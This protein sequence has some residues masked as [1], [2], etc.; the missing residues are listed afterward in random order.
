MFKILIVFHL[1]FTLDAILACRNRG[2]LNIKTTAC[3]FYNGIHMPGKTVF[4]LKRG[5]CNVI[6]SRLRHVG[7]WQWFLLLIE[8][9]TNGRH[10]A[11]DIKC[12]FWNENAWIPIKISLKF[13]PKDPINNIPS[14]VQIMA[15]RRPGDKPLSVPMM[16]SLPTHICVARS[17]W[18]NWRWL[19]K[20]A[21]GSRGE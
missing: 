1:L 2:H 15:W 18:V 19:T 12:I 11:D 3:F 17:Q 10:F 13:V 7:W 21:M 9:E 5:Q 4:I 6:E 8:A 20:Q 14:L 16:I